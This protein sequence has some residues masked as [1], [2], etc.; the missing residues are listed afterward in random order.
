MSRKYKYDYRG[1]SG[2]TEIVFEWGGARVET[3]ARSSRERQ[4]AARSRLVRRDRKTGRPGRGVLDLAYCGVLTA[5][6]ACSR[7]RVYCSTRGLMSDVST[8]LQ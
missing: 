7:V 2:G 6:Y 4:G 3:G 8:S 5:P 1:G